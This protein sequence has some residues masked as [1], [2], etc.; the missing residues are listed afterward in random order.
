MKRIAVVTGGVGALGSAIARA[1]ESADY[2]VHVT[3]SR[4]MPGYRGAGEVHVLDLRDLAGLRQL[5]ARFTEVHA[6]ALS[7]GAFAMGDLANLQASDIDAM[8][9]ANFRTAVN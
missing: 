8:M 7:A 9:D 3:A 4:A 6:L 5:A 1:F 2:D